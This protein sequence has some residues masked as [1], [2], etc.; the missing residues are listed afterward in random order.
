VL[1]VSSGAAQ[2]VV[3]RVADGWLGVDH[4]VGSDRHGELPASE[5][6]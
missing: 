4:A 3:G 1:S 2:G 5:L 6:V